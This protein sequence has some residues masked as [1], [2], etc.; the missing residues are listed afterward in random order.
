MQTPEAPLKIKG[1]STTEIRCDAVQEG[2]WFFIRWDVW[3]AGRD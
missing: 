2:D 1:H 3:I